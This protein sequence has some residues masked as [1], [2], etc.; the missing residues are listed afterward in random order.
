V[1]SWRDLADLASPALG[2]TLAHSLWQTGVLALGYASWKALARSASVSLQYRAALL[3]LALGVVAAGATFWCLGSVGELHQ[4]TSRASG[5]TMAAKVVARVARASLAV[6]VPAGVR[7]AVRSPNV[8]GG[9][10][11]VWTAGEL[12]L[13]FRLLGGLLLTSQIRRR[14][15][16][17]SSGNLH[18]AHGRLASRLGLRQPIELLHSA[19][20]DVP[21]ALGWRRP[22][23]L[24]PTELLRVETAA[25]LESLLA[26][27]L[28]HVRAR[29]YAVNVLQTGLDALF[30]FCPGAR[31]LSADVRRLREF[32]C[33]DDAVALSD[34]PARYVRALARLAERQ[35]PGLPVPAATGPR[36]VDRVRRLSEG[37]LMPRPRATYS[38]ALATLAIATALLGS[39]LLAASRPD[40]AHNPRP[41]AAF[42][43]WICPASQPLPLGR[44]ALFPGNEFVPQNGPGRFFHCSPLLIDGRPVDRTRLTV[45]THGTLTLVHGDPSSATATRIGFRV[46]LR[47]DGKIV[48]DPK[49]A[50]L[51]RA[52]LEADLGKVLAFARPGDQLVVDP[53]DAGDWRA[54]RIIDLHDRGEGC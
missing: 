36:L 20:V 40:T 18:E 46:S 23:V 9:L 6:P 24:L 45:E 29:D 47:R 32:R 52:L 38:L 10:V 34:S 53:V 50:L 44:V 30:F 8:L 11:A 15:I 22:A 4:G 2:L 41:I 25:S 37:D 5:P 31:W 49:A 19:E 54:K 43:P 28:A 48:D 17:I 51:N 12:I 1:S 13:G 7:G 42:T 3:A 14:A 27:E 39:S 33:D 16:R 21:V 26:H 35:N